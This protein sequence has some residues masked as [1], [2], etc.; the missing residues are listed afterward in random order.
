MIVCV[1]R[2]IKTSEFTNEDVL[3]ERIM[4][5]DFKCGLC[6]IQYLNQSENLNQ[7]NILNQIHD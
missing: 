5:N 1:C 3:K 4:Q 2:N 7:K 6:Q